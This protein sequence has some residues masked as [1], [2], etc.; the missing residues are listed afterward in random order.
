[1]PASSMNTNDSAT[2]GCNWIMISL[3]R[4]PL[5]RRRELLKESFTEV[6]GEFLFARSIDSHDTDAIAEFLEQS[7]RGP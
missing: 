5:C 2:G 7:V 1:M 6:E 3:V 4:Q